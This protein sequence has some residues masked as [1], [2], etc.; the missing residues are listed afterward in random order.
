M[1]TVVHTLACAARE[2][3]EKDCHKAGRGRM[4][5][6]VQAGNPVHAEKKL[7]N[8]LNVARSFFKHECESLDERIELD[9]TPHSVRWD[10]QIDPRASGRGG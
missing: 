8:L 5:D 2:I 6:F 10:F 4:F 7:W 9:E 1:D 3:Y